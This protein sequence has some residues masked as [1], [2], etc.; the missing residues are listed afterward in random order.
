MSKRCVIGMLVDTSTSMEVMGYEEILAGCNE[1]LVGQQKNDEKLG[2]ASKFY[3]GTF[4][5]D[6]VMRYNGLSLNSILGITKDDIPINGMT[7]MYDGING[8]INDISNGLESGD[9]VIIFIL[10]DGHENCSKEMVGEKGREHVFKKIK[11]KESM[12]WKFY[13]AGANQDAM[14][15]GGSLGI[16]PKSCISY[17]Y[18]SGGVSNVMRSCSAAL[19][20]N[21]QDEDSNFNESER[22]SSMAPDLVS[23]DE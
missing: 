2:S 5:T 15:V 23:S 22:S 6:Y 13:Y 1:F 3:L 21:R 18:S 11:E 9:N 8:F 19:S 12:G 14:Y 20:R 7:A 16:N 10:T 17:D 4:A